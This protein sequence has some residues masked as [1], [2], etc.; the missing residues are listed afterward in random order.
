MGHVRA[1]NLSDNS[2][3]AVV[4]QLPIQDDLLDVDTCKKHNYKYSVIT[5]NDIIIPPRIETK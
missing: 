4:V 5:K 3:V 1:I 2:G